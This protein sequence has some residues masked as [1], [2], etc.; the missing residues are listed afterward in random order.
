M[1][2][3]LGADARR[4]PDSLRQQV[5][6]L[7]RELALVR[8][9]RATLRRGEFPD[10][11]VPA[12]ALAA[13]CMPGAVSLTSTG[14]PVATTPG[15]GTGGTVALTATVEVPPPI[16]G[17]VIDLTARVHA[18]NGSGAG[19]FLLTRVEVDQVRG[20]ALPVQVASG[21]AGRNDAALTA[22]LEGLSEGSLVPVRVWVASTGGA[23]PA[24]AASTVDLQGSLGWFS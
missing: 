16:T 21:S 1:A 17:C 20:T 18:I 11:G 3:L 4:T 12:A 14:F 6:R 23:W 19:D 22:V 5:R 10:G 9:S 8:S 24:A 13:R 15:D 2:D 7:E